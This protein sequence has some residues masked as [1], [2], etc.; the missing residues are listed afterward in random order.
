VIIGRSDAVDLLRKWSD[1]GTLIRCQGSF[2]LFAFSS[3]GFIRRATES[4]VR[5]MSL[6]TR[7]EVVVQFKSDME[8]GY[9]DNRVIEGVE[10]KFESCLVVFVPPIADGETQDTIAFAAHRISN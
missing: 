8:F 2:S 7:S 3:E 5:L 4:E 1:D 10:K 9:D 6:D